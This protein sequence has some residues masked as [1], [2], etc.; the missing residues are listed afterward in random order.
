MT[1]RI[2]LAFDIE[3]S[4]GRVMD[5]TIAIGASVVDEHFH[6]L[7]FL[8]LPAYYP[9]NTRCPTKFEPRC[10]NEFWVKHQP[11][12]ATLEYKGQLSK[13]QR[14]E[15][16][17]KEFHAFRAKWEAYAD[18]KGIEYLLV[19]DNPIFDGGFIN[20]LLYKHM[21]NVLPIPYRASTQKYDSFLDTHS[22]QRGL[23]F[24][25][26]PSHTK[27]WGVTRRIGEIYD[28]PAV[29]KRHDHNPAND[30]YTIAHEQQV[31]FAIQEGRIQRKQ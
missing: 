23:L 29:K 24:S 9:Q 13:H 19:S 18:A 25:V 7:D 26:D 28:V 14:E 22:E 31:L 15:E 10:W 1:Q 16:M 4:G 12:L 30:A 21:P 2:V 11:T 17:I 6:E 5:D 27:N 3:R 8:F 20:D